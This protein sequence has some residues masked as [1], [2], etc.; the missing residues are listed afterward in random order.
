MGAG[1]EVLRQVCAFLRRVCKN[2]GFSP[3]NASDICMKKEF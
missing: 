2:S 1:Q 3:K